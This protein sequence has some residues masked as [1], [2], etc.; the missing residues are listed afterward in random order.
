MRSMSFTRPGA[1]AR[2]AVFAICLAAAAIAGE[3]RPA[4]A[5]QLCKQGGLGSPGQKWDDARPARGRLHAADA[6]D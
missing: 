1:V 3:D 4:G 5:S 6:P 2:R